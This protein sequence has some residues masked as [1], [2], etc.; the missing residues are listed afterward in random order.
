MQPPADNHLRDIFANFW[1]WAQLSVRVEV[2]YG[3][4]MDHTSLQMSLFRDGTE[5]SLQPLM[6]L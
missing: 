6:L 5:E 4:A 3:L 1:H 2:G